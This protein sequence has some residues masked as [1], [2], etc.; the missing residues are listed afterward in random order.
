MQPRVQWH[1]LFEFAHAG[2]AR[3]REVQYAGVPI[4]NDRLQI[5][6]RRVRPRGRND[7]GF[8]CSGSARERSGE[9]R[10]GPWEVPGAE[11]PR[12]GAYRHSEFQTVGAR[13]HVDIRVMA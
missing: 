7:L 1:D 3:E 8:V 13:G 9:V 5:C 10:G 11:S 6:D 12:F 4:A 2:E